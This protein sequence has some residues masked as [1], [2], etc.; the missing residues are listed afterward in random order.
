MSKVTSYVRSKHPN[1]DWNRLKVVEPIPTIINSTIFWKVSVITNDYRGLVSIDLVNARTSQVISIDIANKR[2]ITGEYVLSLIQKP[3]QASNETI[4]GNK[5]D[6][7]EEIKEIKRKIN[8]TIEQL[9]ELYNRLEELERM[10][11]ESKVGP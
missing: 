10:L 7:I 3:E 4:P 8:E 6:V 11:N 1:F 2:T 9:T 5:T